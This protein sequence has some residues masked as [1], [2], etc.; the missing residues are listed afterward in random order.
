MKSPI[1]WLGSKRRMADTIL[2]MMP[3][4]V[5]YVEPFAGSASV[6]FARDEP[7]KVEV[8]NDI[9][10]ELVNFFRVIQHHLVEFC[11]QFRWSISSRQMFEWQEATPAQTLTDIQRAARFYYL[12]KLAFGARPTGRTFGTATVTPPKLNLVRLE[13]DMSATHQRLA[14]VTIENLPWEKCIERYDRPHTL[15]LLDPPYW[16][17]AG[18]GVPFPLAEYRRLREVI[19]GITGKAILT[20]ND[21]PDMRE[22]FAGLRSRKVELTYTVGRDKTKAKKSA[23][24]IYRSW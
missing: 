11:A 8:L 18:Y 21:H 5:C 17:L 23:E 16:Q 10:N 24:R 15:F 1:A 22:I 20:I 4:H 6:L 12:H 3:D 13:E 7:A 9:N 2:G 14:R 19:A